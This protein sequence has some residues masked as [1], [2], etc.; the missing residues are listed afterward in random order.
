MLKLRTYTHFHLQWG[1][2]AGV[3]GSRIPNKKNVF[4][5]DLRNILIIPWGAL[6]CTP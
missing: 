1:G 3:V 4:Q 6:S 5:T 2:P